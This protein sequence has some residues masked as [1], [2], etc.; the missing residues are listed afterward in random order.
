MGYRIDPGA[1]AGDEV[2]RALAEQLGRASQDLRVPGGPDAEAVHEARKRVKKARSLLRLAR[3]D[4]GP[5]VARHA[6]AELRQVGADLATQRDA[7][8]LVEAVDRLLEA[9]GDDPTRRALEAVRDRFAERAERVRRSGSLDRATVLGAARTLEQLVSWIDLVPAKAEGW[10]ALAPGF[11]RQY[12][13]GRRLLDDLPDEPT[14]DELHEWRKRVKDLWYH[15]RLLRRLWTDGQRPVVAAADELASALGEDHDLGLL[16]AH[17]DVEGGGAPEGAV[18][19]AGHDDASEPDDGADPVEDPVVVDHETWVLVVAA[20]R[21]ERERLQAD[22]RRLGARLYADE[23]AAW[24]DR[25]RA[26]WD[27]AR[28]EAATGTDGVPASVGASGHPAAADPSP[29]GTNA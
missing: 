5:A 7:D 23:P 19:G 22:A 9:A 2:R 11:G 14:A 20:G 25:H 28:D 1:R 26:W 18:G 21:A 13:R 17:L 6:N 3:A 27:A 4:L 8:A 29:D 10:D 24:V 15:Q 12:Q 16:L